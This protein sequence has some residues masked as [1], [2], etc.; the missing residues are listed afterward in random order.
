MDRYVTG[1]C[2]G[3]SSLVPPQAACSSDYTF[4]VADSPT[5]DTYWGYADE[6]ALADRYFQPIA[7]GTSSNDVY[8]AVA[9]Y[10]FRD[11]DIMPDSWGSNCITGQL[12]RPAQGY[13]QL[14]SRT[15]ADELLD[16]GVS[17]AVY[18]DGYG[19]AVA[20]AAGC[21]DPMH[22]SCPC[23][24]TYASDCRESIVFR[25]VCTYDGSDIPFQ[26]YPRFRDDPATTRDYES[27]FVAD[28]AAGELPDFAYVKFRTSRN[29]H[30]NWS[31]ITD[32]E[33]WVDQV[34]STI[35]SSPLYRD[36]TLIILTWDEGGGFYDH[37]SPPASI[38]TFP[39]DDPSSPSMAGQPIPYGTRVPMLVIGPLRAARH[40]LTRAD[41]AL[42][43]RA[44]PRVPL[45]RPL[46]AG[47]ARRAR[48]DGQRHR[49]HAR[50]ERGR[51]DRPLTRA[52]RAL[53]SARDSRSCPRLVPTFVVATCAGP[54][55]P[56]STRRSRGKMRPGAGY[57]P[58]SMRTASIAIL[59][60][61]SSS[62]RL[63]RHPRLS[64]LRRRSP[65][66]RRRLRPPVRVQR[67]LR[68]SAERQ[69]QLRRMR[70]RLRHRPELHVGPLRHLHAELRRPLVR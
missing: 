11:N 56:G 48:R 22:S 65:R 8:L 27:R 18:A 29:E 63:R 60:P 7:G 59:S 30:P 66:R 17:F 42:V 49:Q 50:P 52:A 10:E 40:R 58:P 38:E 20:A 9:H 4:A 68:R 21:T 35:E 24:H 36:N 45:R 67:L 43:N 44:L 34:V 1:G 41:G 55:S 28:V 57:A 14:S 23:T 2:P 32:G 16:R 69:R 61:S 37:V 3:S 70:A 12:S 54:R 15:I 31:Y 13:Q 26:Y 39:A 62:P 6:G 47:R 51:R 19:D 46:R 33:R 53:R 25:Q 64:P 5:L